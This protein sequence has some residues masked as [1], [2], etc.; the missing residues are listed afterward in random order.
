MALLHYFLATNSENATTWYFFFNVFKNIEF[1]KDELKTQ[2]KNYINIKGKIEV[3]E[4]VLEDDCA[5]LLNTYIPRIKSST[6]K[7]TPENNIDCPLGEL[8]LIDIVN[9]KEKIYKK[10][11][12]LIENLNPLIVLAMILYEYPNKKEI[13]ISALLSEER[14]IG[15][16]FNLDIINLL[17]LLYSLERKN[18]IKVVRTAGLDVIRVTKDIDYLQCISEYYNSMKNN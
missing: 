1:T 4:R 6:T 12:I 11:P 8:N 18:Y 2:L 13:K 7:V 3:S 9:K 17:K 14:G 5:C 16:L 15:K 10:A